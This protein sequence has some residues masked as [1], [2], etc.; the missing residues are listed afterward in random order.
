MTIDVSG[1]ESRET[2]FRI[3]KKI[4][5]SVL[6]KTAIAGNDPNWGRIT[7]AA[8]Y[9]GIDFDA[10][11]LSLKIN[12]TDVYSSGVPVAFDE[13]ELSCRMTENSDV[14]LLLELAGGPASGECSVR[15]WTSDLTQEYVRLNSEYTT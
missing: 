5:N 7:S 9:A 6:V 8:G 12:G 14:H 1:F 15:F 4:A 3:S 13:A 11:Q 2:A 10:N